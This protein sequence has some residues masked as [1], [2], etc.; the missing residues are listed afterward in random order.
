MHSNSRKQYHSMP[1]THDLMLAG[2]AIIGEVYENCQ[3][4]TH[5]A[6]PRIHSQHNSCQAA[7]AVILM[8]CGAGGGLC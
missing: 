8:L 3:P 7:F 5:A 4:R 1:F 6:M 2:S